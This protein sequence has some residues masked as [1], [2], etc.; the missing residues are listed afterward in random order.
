MKKADFLKQGNG[1]RFIEDL[2]KSAPDVLSALTAV[3]VLL[4]LVNSVRGM[5]K[6]K[7]DRRP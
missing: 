1:S 3:M 2:T 7:G 5:I 4:A 6:G